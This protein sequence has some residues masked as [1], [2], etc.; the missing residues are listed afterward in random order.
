MA[1]IETLTEVAQWQ[2]LWESSKLAAAPTLLIFKRSPICPTSHFAERI[3][4]LFAASLPDKLALRIYSVDVIGA[5]PVSQRIAADTGITH[6][7]PQT[8]LIQPGQKV[9]WHASHEDIERDALEKNVGSGGLPAAEQ[10]TQGIR[11]S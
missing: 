8:L 6:Q 4:N 5:R 7:S 11:P 9:A 2:S 3:F 1:Q 10:Q